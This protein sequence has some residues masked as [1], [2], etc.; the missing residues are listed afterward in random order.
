MSWY[1]PNCTLVMGKKRRNSFAKKSNFEEPKILK[2]VRINSNKELIPQIQI[3][4]NQIVQYIV[5]EQLKES[6]SNKIEIDEN[7]HQD[8]K[9]KINY[10][11]KI[12][13]S[14][15]EEIEKPSIPNHNTLPNGIDESSMPE[16]SQDNE[17]VKVKMNKR[18]GRGRKKRRN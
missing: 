17:K 4:S 2:K 16:E 7:G 8:D 18:R 3:E 6:N 11:I 9:Y 14:L 13:D 1:C 5:E 15:A 10:A 12:E